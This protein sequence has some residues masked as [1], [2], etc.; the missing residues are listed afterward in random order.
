MRRKWFRTYAIASVMRIHTILSCVVL[1]K[2][3]SFIRLLKRLTSRRPK[4]RLD[5]V[6]RLHPRVDVFWSDPISIAR[7]NKGLSY[8][9]L[10]AGQ[11][12]VA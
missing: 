7:V 2:T 5:G 4:I 6:V 12:I 3:P 1:L 11:F 9:I 10:V 8:H